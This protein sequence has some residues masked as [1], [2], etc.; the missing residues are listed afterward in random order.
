MATIKTEGNQLNPDTYLELYDF[1]MTSIGGTVS[2]ITN[3]PTG[4]GSTGIVWR[5]HTYFAMP[6][7]V[8]DLET[9]A[10]GSVLARPMLTVSNVNKFFMAAVLTLGDM[11]GTK[12][13]K[14][15]TFQKFTDNGS[16]P[17][18]NAYM[19]IEEF[20]ITKKNPSSLKTTLSFELTSALDRPGLM[21]PRRQILRDLGFPG[22]SRQRVR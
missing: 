15:R 2:Y 20:V 17:N 4:G 7:E 9:K 11:I 1:D 16:E 13:T 14:W 10:D 6:I 18:I 12:V 5:G 19:P 22:V 8:S 3:T 21:L